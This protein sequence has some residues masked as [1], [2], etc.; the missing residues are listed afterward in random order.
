MKDKI[1]DKAE[2]PRPDFERSDWISLNGQ[3]DFVF[4]YDNE[5]EIPGIPPQVNF[6]KKIVVPFCYESKLSGLGTDEPCEN[7][8]YK[9]SFTVEGEKLNGKSVLLKFGAVDYEAKVWINGMYVGMHVGGFTPF[10]FE[11][12]GFLRGGENTV[13]VKTKDGYSKEQP[14]GKQ[15]WAQKPDLCWYTN[16]SGI[17][18]SVWLEFTGYSY[19]TG[20]HITPD[21]DNNRCY[22]EI[23]TNSK[24]NDEISAELSR[25]GLIYGIMTTSMRKGKAFIAYEFEELAVR[26]GMDLHWSPDSPNLIDV[27]LKL[28]RGGEV[29]DEVKTYFGMRKISFKNGRIYL[30]NEPLYQR[31]VLDQGYWPD[32]LMTPPSDEAI[33][34][35]IELTK[36]LGFNGARKHQKIE[37]PR[38]YYWA[39]RLGLLIW[40]ELPSAYAYTSTSVN[41]LIRDM[42]E[43]II[44]DY[45][46]PC[47]ITW[48]PLNESWGVDRIASNSKQQN[49]AKMIYYFIKSLD[50]T[51]MIST[52]DGWEQVNPTD[53]SGIHDYAMSSEDASNKYKD[54]KV[55]KVLSTNAQ[56]KAM[57]ADGEY[58]TGEPILMTEYGGIKL[59][60]Y[61]GWGYDGVAQ[62]AEEYID[63][64]ERLTL[65]ITS[66]IEIC[67]F[68]YTQL[69]DVMQEV[70]G[71][72]DENRNP[73]ADIKE[74]SSVFLG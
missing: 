49:F 17:W 13:L 30:N 47:I 3:W 52:N 72:L 45:N 59:E 44:R 60:G 73:K 41:A 24:E 56:F 71:L 43:F 74:I 14:R 63:K 21:I 12:A 48:V 27:H 11:I 67:G 55:L 51:R 64:I 33:R 66:N 62:N 57:Y 16:T 20:V 8:W 10:E 46:H 18:Q 1:I 40:G 42:N 7:L 69:T 53:M 22:I 50:N 35:D 39:D 2:Y 34:L 5:Y 6:N 68:C 23:D 70:N 37:D 54:D 9:R 65:A 58:Y 32:S 29:T 4:D 25:D 31:L 36:K 19:I 38:Y 15:M 26:S 61:A 28:S